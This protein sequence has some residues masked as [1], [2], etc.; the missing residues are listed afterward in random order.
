MKLGETEGETEEGRSKSRVRVE[1]EK[2]DMGRKGN[3]CD[4]GGAIKHT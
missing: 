3:A 2:K 1:R 4:M